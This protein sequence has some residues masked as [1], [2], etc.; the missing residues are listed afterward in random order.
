MLPITKTSKQID[1]HCVA[2]FLDTIQ[3]IRTHYIIH[4][5]DAI[6]CCCI[7]TREG[8]NSEIFKDCPGKC[9]LQKL[10]GIGKR[11][12]VWKFWISA[13]KQTSRLFRLCCWGW[14]K[15]Q[16][17]YAKYLSYLKYSHGERQPCHLYKAWEA[18]R[19][20]KWE[21]T[22]TI[23]VSNRDCRE[24]HN[25]TIFFSTELYLPQKKSMKLLRN[26][27]MKQVLSD[28]MHRAPP[29]FIFREKT[30]GQKTESSLNPRSSSFVA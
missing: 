21:A 7:L 27:F 18:G 6:F 22:V 1:D 11:G 15:W 24:T 12:S 2:T 3:T 29:S 26:L 20:L 28:N 30:T 17:S 5:P 16:V 13:S 19:H 23:S 8:R 9:S 10:S 4:K 25:N 14:H